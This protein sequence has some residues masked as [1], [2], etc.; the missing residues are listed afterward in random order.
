MILLC[1]SSTP[2]V[3]W[4]FLY[5]PV[6]DYVNKD[7]AYLLYMYRS[8]FFFYNV[9]ILS[10]CAQ[11]PQGRALPGA[12]GG[13]VLDVSSPLAH[14]LVRALM[15]VRA[16]MIWH[17]GSHYYAGGS[18][19]RKLNQSREKSSMKNFGWR[20]LKAEYWPNHIGNLV[21]HSESLLLLHLLS[22]QEFKFTGF[23][24][25]LKVLYL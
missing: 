9:Y 20:C 19:P 16:A 6:Q 7:A 22:S 3:V 25:G 17:L 23:Q 1:T 15:L 4:S 24:V 11:T 10:L 5:K 2:C 8:F 12:W 13:R 14:C 18:S 21:L